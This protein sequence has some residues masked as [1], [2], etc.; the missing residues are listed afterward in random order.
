MALFPGF[1]S[2]KKRE[3]QASRFNFYY[4]VRNLLTDISYLSV[5]LWQPARKVRT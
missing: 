1:F 2:K 5:A 3:A 4:D